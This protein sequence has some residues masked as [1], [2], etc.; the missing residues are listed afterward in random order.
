MGNKGEKMKGAKKLLVAT[1]CATASLAA[2]AQTAY[3]RPT[4]QYPSQPPVNGPAAVQL[5]DSPFFLTPYLGS[6]FGYDDNLFYAR[7]DERDSY[8]WMLSPG[9]TADARDANKVL[10]L[11][12][13]N[14]IGR[15]TSSPNDNYVDNTSRAQFDM[16]LDPHNFLRFAYDYVLGHEPRGSTDRPITGRPDR[17]RLSSP[18][19]TYAL[20]APGAKGRVEVYYSDPVRHYL[21]NREFTTSSDREQQ[22]FGG[23]FYWRVAPRTYLMAEARR[24][25]VSY[26]LPGSPLSA[27]ESRYYGGV[28]WEA[29]AA[30]RGTIKV[31]RLRR[32]F[33][34]PDEPTFSGSSWEGVISWAPR[35]YSKFDFYTARQTNESTGLGNFIL[36]SIAGVSWTHDWSSF[37][38]TA[39]DARY[40]KDDYQGFDRTDKYK[41][42]GLKAGYRYRRWLT[43]GAEYAHTTRDSSSDAFEY[44]K[45][46]Y[47][48][49]FTAS[50]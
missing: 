27:R 35:S 30:T 12:Y 36:T 4:Y 15:Y 17:Y 16:A 47:L 38:T 40:Q 19:F 34:N 44:D 20:G 39:V 45:N 2:T 50:M 28:T 18:S 46:L 48:I 29:T 33:D 25:D 31:G 23:A 37:L 7:T 21:D 22:E 24:T 49:T 9:F 26:E 5:G 8:Y 1:F 3:V 32:D 41:V 6:G 42:V 10:Q 43:M 13:Q 11:S 14:Q